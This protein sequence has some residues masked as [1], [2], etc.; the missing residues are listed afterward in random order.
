[1]TDTFTKPAPAE[2]DGIADWIG[3]ARLPE[4]SVTVY[5]RA[6]L[7]ADYDELQEQLQS[8]LDAAR[9]DDRLNSR[10]SSVAAELAELREEMKSSAKTFRFRALTRAEGKSINDSAPKNQAGE[11]DDDYVAEQWVA[12]ACIEPKVTPAQV[13]D[14]RARIGEGQFAALW[15]TAYEVSTKKRHD[16]PFLPAAW[17]ALNTKDS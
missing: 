13:T 3:S 5:G 9:N 6:D 8:A 11:L 14:I 15:Q 7:V 1:M 2:A 4:K 17:A 12:K 16:L 10:A